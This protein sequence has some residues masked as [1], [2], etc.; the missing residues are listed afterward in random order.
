MKNKYYY[1]VL[2][3]SY[4]RKNRKY[5][6]GSFMAA[7]DRAMKENF[8]NGAGFSSVMGMLGGVS[9]IIKSGVDNAQIA[10]TTGL[11]N[12]MENMGKNVEASS[13]DSLMEQWGTTSNIGNQ[14]SWR[15]VRGKTDGELAGS[16]LG[17]GLSGAA[18]GAS[19][20]PIG[21]I[22]GGAIGL[23][24]S[25]IG[26]AVGRS[27]AERK[28]GQLNDMANEANLRQ[29]LAFASNADSIM[30]Q[31]NLAAMSTLAAHGG[32][33]F[34]KPSKRG[35]F[36]AAAKK[37]G[38][39]VQEFAS[40]VLANKDRYSSAMV[41]KANFARNFGGHKKENG[42]Y[43][44]LSNI[45]SDK[46]YFIRDWLT[47]RLPIRTLNNRGIEPIWID[48]NMPQVSESEL[49]TSR[50]L[51]D[52]D[53][54]EMYKIP[55]YETGSKSKIFP[56]II[57]TEHIDDYG[58]LDGLMTLDSFNEYG[59]GRF[60]NNPYN[61]TSPYILYNTEEL[62]PAVIVHERTHAVPS[63][64]PRK[65]I[66]NI[67]TPSFK[68]T[69]YLDGVERDDYYDNSW[70][71]YSRLMEFRHNNNLD[72]N[73]EVTLE[74][75]KKMRK[76]KD[77]K[78]YGI[79]NRYN[80]ETLY[81][82]F[83]NVAQSNIGKDVS[84]MAR[85]GGH[86]KAEG[87]NKQTAKNILKQQVSMLTGKSTPSEADT[88]NTLMSKVAS[89]RE[90]YTS[91]IYENLYP[92][93]LAD[94]IISPTSRYVD[95]RRAHKYRTAIRKAD[96]YMDLRNKGVYNIDN[97][98]HPLFEGFDSKLAREID[99]Y[100]DKYG[101]TDAQ[102]AAFMANLWRENRFRNNHRDT[103]IGAVHG[104]FQFNDS[105]GEGGSDTYTRY[106][107]WLKKNNKKD[108]RKSQTEF[109]V[110]EYMPGRP[111]YKSIWMNPDATVEELS[112]YLIRDVYS[113]SQRED[114]N[115]YPRYRNASRAL[116]HKRALGGPVTHGGEFSN[117]ITQ[118][119]NG[120]LHEQNPMEGVPMGIAPDGLPNLVEEGE[121][122]FNDYVFSNRLRPKEKDLEK[123]KLKKFKN[124][125]FAQIA[126]S[127]QKE[128]EERPNDPIS[129]NGLEDSMAK[130]TALQEMARAVEGKQGANRLKAC[131][132][133]KYSGLFN[134]DDD[135]QSKVRVYFPPLSEV[136][137]PNG[138]IV[139]L[140][141]VTV[142]AQRP[143]IPS[144][145]GKA[146]TGV[147]L[148]DRV[149]L[150][151]AVPPRLLTEINPVVDTLRT[152]R[153]E[154][155]TGQTVAPDMDTYW[156]RQAA[157]RGL[158][159]ASRDVTPV[160]VQSPQRPNIDKDI[161]RSIDEGV[162][163]AQ[164][165]A[166]DLGEVTNPDLNLSSEV[167]VDRMN[168]PDNTLPTGLRYAPVVG[169]LIGSIASA[170]AKPDY[171]HSNSL[172]EAASR[173]RP[174]RVRFRPVGNYMRYTPLNTSYM[175]NRLNAET[176][177]TRRALENM[178]GGNAAAARNQLAALNRS[179]Q[180]A[181]GDAFIKAEQYNDNLKRQ[182]EEFNRG[183]NMFNSQG[184][185][186][187]DSVNAQM[188]NAYDARRLAA[189]DQAMRM[190]EASDAALE[191]SRALN[192]TNLFDNL[193]DIGR[194]N[195][196]FNQTRI[197]GLRYGYTDKDGNPVWLNSYG[198]MLTKRTGKRRRR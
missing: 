119:N 152:P 122:I 189:I 84:H 194:E 184:A 13:L 12:S 187:A 116:L 197:P 126:R 117:G 30:D 42:G 166:E 148:K 104:M 16:I 121:V 91:P 133:R 100:L 120:G 89:E 137:N 36:T 41:K 94:S 20:G 44:E 57:G 195:F 193:G 53:L 52:S 179:S 72:P 27:K 147:P 65:V 125:T 78:D 103:Q 35:T 128:S 160:F 113:P 59:A 51:L 23:I 34:I 46:G 18:A 180:D 11:E 6:N 68:G 177:G 134:L 159:S 155:R 123:M 21:A 136:Y 93:E 90:N 150:R 5:A 82:L 111:N 138:E 79:L 81:R 106:L 161:L 69:P 181:L 4:Y 2:P 97:D 43:N 56:S 74:D 127:L 139:E 75:I 77:I 115:Y 98:N 146:E 32:K 192:F 175:M 86:L 19:A 174:S 169:S 124:R 188:Q 149:R 145:R 151:P 129:K 73:K 39:G 50:Y 71:V 95:S 29:Q 17:S 144:V 28:A 55:E 114:P 8:S 48:G 143:S 132:G 88:Y 61:N 163:A 140:N 64:G 45:A 191:Q 105:K 102:R 24:G 67:L 186:Q 15:D 87:G 3:Y 101:F 70:E 99:G 60:N 7:Q 157:S 108:T 182:V 164:I 190:R 54:N 33:I 176:A 142:S 141:P 178:S 96:S 37:R 47:Q 173:Q 183:T 110:E 80:D 165:A 26:A 162:V 25:G 83:N 58:L 112:D 172:L 107:N 40:R 49:N 1:T 31:Q 131:G 109:F 168:V 22:V 158:P 171:E 185:M 196:S 10:D 92:Q 167:K 38:M 135:P 76:N 118:I 63:E 156:A 66:D 170:F 9:D 14:Y 130:L 198:G 62:S 85:Y 153:P 154:I